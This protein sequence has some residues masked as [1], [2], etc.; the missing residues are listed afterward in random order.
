MYWILLNVVKCYGLHFI[1]KWNRVIDCV[2][3]WSVFFI[4][5]DSLSSCK[6][7]GMYIPARSVCVYE[8]KMKP[9]RGRSLE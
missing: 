9:V 3:N 4:F 1:Q 8:T 6:H 5:F 7:F 2:S